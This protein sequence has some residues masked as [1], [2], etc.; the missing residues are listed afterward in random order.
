MK[1]DVQP[2][3]VSVDAADDRVTA[4]Q[5][6]YAP[7]SLAVYDFIVH[8]LSNHALW[9]CPTRDL[10]E[11]YDRN[12]SARHVDVGVGTGYF[13]SH[14]RWP[15]ERPQV[16][17]VDLN[18]HCLSRAARRIARLKPER[19]KANVLEPWPAEAMGSSYLSA[20]LC[21]LLH[22]VPGAI[23]QKAAV[24][25]HLQPH[26]APGARIFGATIVQGDAPRNGAARALMAAYNRKGVFSNEQDR[27]EDLDAALRLRFDD[28]RVRLAGC[29]ALFE[30]RARSAS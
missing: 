29:V 1:R 21:Y 24:F 16:T 11:L 20:G 14:A 4:G 18:P 6:V 9:R 12:V 27:V 2:E 23:P 19:V 15:V 26:L 5:A 17:L 7:L 13:L 30:A 8:G 28:V 3:P 25:D 10:Q 22:C